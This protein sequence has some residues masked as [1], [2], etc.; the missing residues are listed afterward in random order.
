[1][2][3]QFSPAEIVELGIQLEKLR[4]SRFPVVALMGKAS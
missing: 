1:M 2:T 4:L 3:Q